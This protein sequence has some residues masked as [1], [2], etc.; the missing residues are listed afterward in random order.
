LRVMPETWRGGTK[1]RT[2]SNLNE[3]CRTWMNKILHLQGSGAYH[4]H[5][6]TLQSDTHIRHLQSHKYTHMTLL[7]AQI[8]TQKCMV[9][10]ACANLANSLPP[11]PHE[12]KRLRARSRAHIHFQNPTQMTKVGFRGQ[13]MRILNR[14]FPI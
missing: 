5:I 13:K 2:R 10:R 1:A 11:D 8:H 3:P 12:H 6:E 4:M 7:F 14:K 9:A